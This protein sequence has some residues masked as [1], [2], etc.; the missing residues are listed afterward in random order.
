MGLKMISFAQDEMLRSW[1]SKSELSTEVER[2]VGLF[3]GLAHDCW[4]LL[5]C[6][7]WCTMSSQTCE[8][9]QISFSSYS[10]ME[11]KEE[12]RKAGTIVER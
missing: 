7:M 2:V 8:R 4:N 1:S 6:R 5:A 9:R 11:T 12:R 10:M 3:K